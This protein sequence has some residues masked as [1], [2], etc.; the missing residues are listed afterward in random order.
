MDEP[1]DDMATVSGSSPVSSNSDDVC[2]F[3]NKAGVA[4]FHDD[5]NADLYALTHQSQGLSDNIAQMHALMTFYERGLDPS[6]KNG[7]SEDFDAKAIQLL[8]RLSR[9]FIRILTRITD[10]MGYRHHIQGFAL[11]FPGEQ[12]PSFAGSRGNHQMREPFIHQ[13]GNY[14]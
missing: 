12:Q 3:R 8:S 1:G 14:F 5:L 10:V 2:A 4:G 11:K 9:A 6:S 7:A 13:P